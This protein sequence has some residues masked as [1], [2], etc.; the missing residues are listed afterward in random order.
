MRPI[1]FIL[2]SILLIVVIF[3]CILT[4]QQKNNTKTVS[5]FSEITNKAVALYQKAKSQ[6]VDFSSGPCLGTIDGY[7]IDVSHT[8][9]E[10]IDDLAQNQCPDYNSRKV[11]HFVELTPFGTIIRI[12]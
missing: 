5:D 3:F 11:K 10:E 2:I 1:F 9:R 12:K 4:F 7:A 6:R 8:P